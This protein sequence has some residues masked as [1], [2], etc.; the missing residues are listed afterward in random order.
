MRSITILRFSFFKSWQTYLALQRMSD[1][2]TRTLT[3]IRAAQ[4]TLSSSKKS[5]NIL[6]GPFT[7]VENLA[8]R[9]YAVS[10]CVM[11]LPTTPLQ[12]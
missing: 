10:I 3:V 1:P 9:I 2:M 4:S 5:I 6:L 7:R 12:T 8:V 11:L